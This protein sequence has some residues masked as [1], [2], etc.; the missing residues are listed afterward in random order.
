MICRNVV[1]YP[2]GNSHDGGVNAKSKG[3]ELFNFFGLHRPGN[4]HNKTKKG[5]DSEHVK[6]KEV[7]DHPAKRDKKTEENT[8]HGN[9]R[10]VFKTS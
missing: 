9:L 5:D 7:S 1:S 3:E 10:H 4:T 2:H 8:G 6:G